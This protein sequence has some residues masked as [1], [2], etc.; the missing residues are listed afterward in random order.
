MQSK[1]PN[2]P[3]KQSFKWTSDAW[4]CLLKSLSRSY[5]CCCLLTREDGRA[6]SG[7]QAQ[8]PC[9]VPLS[10][11]E[12]P[13]S[14]Q[15]GSGMQ[16]V[17]FLNIRGF[18]FEVLA[19][20]MVTGNC[21]LVGTSKNQCWAAAS[22]AAASVGCWVTRRDLAPYFEVF[23]CIIHS[24][25]TSRNN[26]YSRSILGISWTVPRSCRRNLCASWEQNC[27]RIKWFFLL[28]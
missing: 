18:N 28:F 13:G 3:N 1:Y 17:R 4:T 15:R 7:L 16:V 26:W 12:E 9:C 20:V 2:H 19:L 27:R 25:Q 6:R 23:W 21:S 14:L 5:S 8:G 11:E 10:R 24:D 22:W